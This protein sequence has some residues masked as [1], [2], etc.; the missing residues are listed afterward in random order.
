[1]DGIT[2]FLIFVVIF[3]II[4]IIYEILK[5]LKKPEERET[6]SSFKTLDG[7]I[8]RSKGELVIDDYLHRNNI[9]HVYEK[10]IKVHGEPI[11]YDWY[12]PKYKIYIEYWGYYGKKYKKRKEE[13]IKLY[14]KGKLKLISIENLMFKDIYT[15]LDNE[16][17]KYIDFNSIDKIKRHCP[18]C[19]TELDDRF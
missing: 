3:V 7:H 6:V 1:M 16:L 8:V 10:T 9:E 18:Q 17:K 11:K 19:G 4:V 14:R 2:I 12:L 13:K 5:A 15:N